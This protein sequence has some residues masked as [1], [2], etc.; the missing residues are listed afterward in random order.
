MRTTI[1]APTVALAAAPV[2]VLTGAEITKPSAGPT[3][4]MGQILYTITLSVSI[5]L[6]LPSRDALYIAPL[7]SG[8]YYNSRKRRPSGWHVKRYRMQK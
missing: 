5:A 2:A 6:E 7:R 1:A 4:T 3:T 8:L